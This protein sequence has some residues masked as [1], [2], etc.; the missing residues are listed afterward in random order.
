VNS[1]RRSGNIA[2]TPHSRG[3]LAA[4][5][6]QAQEPAVADDRLSDGE[7]VVNVRA[8]SSLP[9]RRTQVEE[10]RVMIQPHARVLRDGQTV[11]EGFLCDELSPAESV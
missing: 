10:P 9:D 2:L 6:K 1:R 11:T 5:L 7:A 3:V 4:A 8:R